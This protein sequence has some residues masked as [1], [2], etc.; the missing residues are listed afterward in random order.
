[1]DTKPISTALADEHD[2]F[3]IA[4][5]IPG[6]P[7]QEFEKNDLVEDDDLSTFIFTPPAHLPVSPR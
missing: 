1:M 3:G 2:Y 5:I 7:Y 6:F 4:E